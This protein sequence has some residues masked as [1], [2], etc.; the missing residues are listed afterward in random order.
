[1]RPEKLV[2]ETALLL[3]AASTVE[4]TEVASIVD[5]LVCQVGPH[6]RSDRILIGM[7]LEPAAVWDYAQGHVFLTRLGHPDPDF[8]KV[9]AA[10][11]QA[12]AARGRERMPHRELE[13]AWLQAGLEGQPKDGTLSTYDVLMNPIDLLGGSRED[14]YTFTHAVMYIGDFG[15]HPTAWPRPPADIVAEA[16]GSLALSLDDQDYDLAGEVLMTWPLTSSSWSA[17]AAFG[18]SVLA[19]VEDEAGFL[20]SHTVSLD[21]L[22]SLEGD[23]H[24]NYLLA[25]T[26]HTA[27]VMGMLCSLALQPERAPP[28]AIPT[29][30]AV[31]GAADVIAPF[32]QAGER[33][34]HWL[35]EFEKLESSE[36]DSL[37]SMLFAIGVRRLVEARQFA[38]LRQLLAT[39]NRLGLSD[40]P[41][42][43]QTAE[44]L[45]R[46]GVL[47]EVLGGD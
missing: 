21:R 6:A 45:A 31:E 12:Q 16:E 41:V 15:I 25:T 5:D 13:R 27:Y 28:N 40:S 30:L 1:L 20:P 29:D 43:S 34:P 44:L 36:R 17:S 7:T 2:A 11:A 46:L 32:L 8:D 4:E 22:R 18:F 26:Y 23:D 19:A 10:G 39:C 9:L 3:L 47:S 33:R 38:S 42:A 37:A 14:V 24:T 35:R